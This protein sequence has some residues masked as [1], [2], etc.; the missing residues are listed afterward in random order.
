M[1]RKLNC[2]KSMAKIGM[3]VVPVAIA[4]KIIIDKSVVNYEKRQRQNI[5][6]I[7]RKVID[8]ISQ[9]PEKIEYVKIESVI[10]SVLT[11]YNIYNERYGRFQARHGYKGCAYAS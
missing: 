3:I 10:N 2:M 9:T 11:Y 4:T 5:E 1:D 6:Q 7:K 8:N